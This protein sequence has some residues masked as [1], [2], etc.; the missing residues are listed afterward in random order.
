LGATAVPNGYDSGLLGSLTWE[1][2]RK[3]LD[4]S[5]LRHLGCHSKYIENMAYFFSKIK[6]PVA[7]GCG[8][9]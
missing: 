7:L 4:N 3:V 5:T 1:K 6:P 9:I 8:L 2:I